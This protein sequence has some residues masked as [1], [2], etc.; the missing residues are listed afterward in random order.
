MLTLI[1][2]KILLKSN[3]Y[4]LLVFVVGSILVGL[5]YQ[6]ALKSEKNRVYEQYQQR[7]EVHAK[8][9]EAEFKRSF[10]Q[11]ASV[12]NLF[13]SSSWVSF[14]EFSEFVS[15]VFPDFPPERRISTIYRFPVKD[16]HL[17]ISKIRKNPEPEYNNFNIFDF[18]PPNK[19][20]EASAVDNYYNVIGYTYPTMKNPHF[21]GR[22]ISKKSPIGPLV[23]P[24]VENKV[25]L[26]STF[27]SAIKGVTREPF[28]LYMHPILTHSGKN[29]DQTTVTGLILSNQLISAFFNQSSLNI[30]AGNF[31]YVIVDKS[32][33]AYHFPSKKLTR[34]GSNNGDKKKALKQVDFR[35]TIN[36]GNNHF[37]LIIIPE[38]QQ[39]TQI[40]SLLF[41]LLVAGLTL[42]CA[43]TF[44]TQSMLSQQRYLT[45]EVA[46]KTS[47]INKQTR[48]LKVQNHQLVTAVKAAEASANAKS[49]FLANMSHEIRTPLNGVIGLTE[50]IKQTQLD[51]QQREYINKLAFSG[52]H[53]LSVINDILDFS[54]IEAGQIVLEN[55]AFSIHSIIDN[56]NT[57]FEQVTLDKGIAFH[58]LFEGTCH[59]DLMGDAFRINQVLIN[60]CS[61]AIKF[62]ETGSV[63][64]IISMEKTNN[65]NEIYN[66]Q[67]QIIDTGIGISEENINHLFNKFSQADT[68]TTRKYGGT[69]LGL[70]IS[71]KLCHLMGG[72]ITVTSE[73]GKGSH[74]TAIMQINLN[75]AILIENSHPNSIDSKVNILVVDDNPI[76]LKIITNYLQ[77][78]SVNTIAALTAKEGLLALKNEK[79]NIQI[80]ISDWTMPEIDGAKFIQKIATLELLTPPKIIIMSAYETLTIE[81]AKAALPIETVLQKP[82]L[83]ETLYQ[84]IINCLH[85]K[86]IKKAS[87]PTE[88]TLNNIKILVAEDNK[89]NQLVINKVLK[90]EGA[91]VTTVNNG[92]EAVDKVNS[93]NTFDI[94]L[95]DIHMPEMDGIEATKLIRAHKNS[96]IAQLPIVALTANVMAK[97]VAHYL[98]IGM[99]AHESKPINLESLLKTLAPFI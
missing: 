72:E 4:A 18:T 80:V 42:V 76:A 58:I 50:L 46:R 7:A 21:I 14:T 5:S 43:L 37:N 70:S 92:K 64:V 75:S 25:P 6:Q 82:C 96:K 11:V 81:N 89:I 33:N 74:F 73:Q 67:F 35:Y 56:L 20:S 59:P 44:I 52:K 29:S 17:L 53:L 61:N 39:L 34:Y 12:A 98:E 85:N 41:E 16:S 99:N 32:N 22:A 3:Q 1:K 27:S 54:K 8:D 91:I 48:Q 94:I 84:A 63:T 77:R 66:L 36:A 30:A 95:M 79:N 93:A 68:S 97:D 86:P 57:S 83:T 62:T 10:F 9:I 65:G 28:I 71:Q 26:I 87:T 55:A 60:L 88:K 38:D 13:S 19:I 31:S 47:A 2:N 45:E 51:D 69:G 23:F 40:D 24:A 90:S 78:I 49:E 15:R